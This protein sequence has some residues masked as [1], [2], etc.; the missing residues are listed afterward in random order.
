MSASISIWTRLEPRPRSNDLSGSLAAPLRDPLWFLT[1]QWQVGEF[2]GRDAGSLAYVDYFGSESHLPRFTIKGTTQNVDPNTPLERQTLA[3][4]FTPDLSLRVE[5]AQLFDDFLV[6]RV[7]DPTVRAKLRAAFFAQA[8]YV[9]QDLP[10]TDELNP[11]DPATK[12]FLAVCL[13]RSLDGY[14]LYQLAQSVAGGLAVPDTITTIQSEKAMIAS[15]LGD[16]LARVTGVFGVLGTGDPAAWTSPRLEYELAVVAADPGGQGNATLAATPDSNGE[17][18]WYS[19][20]ATAVNTSAAEAAPNPI[21]RTIIPGSARFPSMP[22]PR[23]WYIEENTLSYPDVEPTPTDII[24]LLVTDIMLVHGSDWFLL[25]FD[26]TLGTAVLTKGLVV[27]DVFGHRNLVSAANQPSQPA[28][29]NR[30]TMF[31]TTDDSQGLE[32]LTNYFLVPPSPLSLAQDGATLEDVRFARD[33][34]ADM[35]WAI[36]R[37]TES[38][39]GEPR[40]GRERDAEID[41]RQNLPP[42]PP[43]DPSAALVY[44]VESTVPANW[45]P[46]L[47]VLANPPDPSSVVLERAAMLHPTTTGVGVVL[48]L[49]RF[50]QPSD[51]SPPAPPRFVEEE[52]PRDGLQLVRAVSRSRW[53]DGSTHLWVSRRRLAGAGESQSGLRFDSALVN[54]T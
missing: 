27:T 54:Q 39:I 40:S 47:G 12:R 16:L 15:A 9:L 38:P 7:P 17:F 25:P 45:T 26:Q 22:N 18:D 41:A 37:V 19:F 43:G 35:A 50:L 24:K 31:S 34:V 6:T 20:D 2:Q 11:V 10:D 51:V 28:G 32:H 36:E 48:P 4:P 23:F 52:V 44:S 14:A 13:L 46:L 5:L 42:P 33:E 29:V 53:Y 8:Q 49:G 1:R 3:E 21:H 30:W